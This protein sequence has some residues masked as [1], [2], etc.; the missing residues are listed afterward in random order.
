[1]EL[2]DQSTHHC[3]TLIMA[4]RG[5][6]HFFPD[7]R[8]WYIMVWHPHHHGNFLDTFVPANSFSE[9]QSSYQLHCKN[10][11]LHIMLGKK[12]IGDAV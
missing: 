7:T 9:E 11:M 3:W 4:Q 8:K 10:K 12:C 1:M 5:V 2:K 6:T